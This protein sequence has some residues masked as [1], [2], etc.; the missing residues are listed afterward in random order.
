MQPTQLYKYRD[1]SDVYL[2]R[3][4]VELLS[5]RM[6]LGPI[7]GKCIIVCLCSNVLGYSLGLL[8]TSQCLFHHLDQFSEIFALIPKLAD[9]LDSLNS[10]HPFLLTEAELGQKL[11][12]CVSCSLIHICSC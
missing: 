4:A 3:V 6:T 10:R 11:V 7:G 1:G 12:L 9:W 8:N 2:N 5:E